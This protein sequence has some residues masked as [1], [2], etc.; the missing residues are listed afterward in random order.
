M[1][2]ATDLVFSPGQDTIHLFSSPSLMLN[3][4]RRFGTWL[5]PGRAPVKEGAFAPALKGSIEDGTTN[6]KEGALSQSRKIEPHTGLL[7]LWEVHFCFS[8]QSTYS[9]PH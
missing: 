4:L 7:C 8:S 1:S 6:R 3:L 9:C 2:R 5:C